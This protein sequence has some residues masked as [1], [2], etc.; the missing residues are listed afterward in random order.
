MNVDGGVDWI[1]ICTDEF[2]QMVSFYRDVLRLP[3]A[4]QGTPVIDRQFTR[5]ALVRMPDVTL[6]IVESPN[7]LKGPVVCLTVDDV[8]QARAE[9]RAR[10]LEVITPVL[11]D[12]QGWG[13]TYVRSP[14]GT[15][16]QIQGPYTA[17]VD[18]T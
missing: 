5:Y 11:S 1:L 4:E 15:V 16:Y 6:E 12:G 14:D 9:M 8:A 13:W 17:A 2:D 18:T 3:I 10:R 7:G